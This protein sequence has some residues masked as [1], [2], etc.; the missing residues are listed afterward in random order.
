MFVLKSNRVLSLYP[1]FICVVR[2]INS[3][4]PRACRVKTMDYRDIFR[5]LA[6]VYSTEYM[7]ALK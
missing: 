3:F 4:V 2:I 7:Y 6:T 5:D 1:I